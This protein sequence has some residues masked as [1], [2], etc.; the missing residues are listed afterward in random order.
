VNLSQRPLSLNQL[1]QRGYPHGGNCVILGRAGWIYD[2]NSMDAGTFTFLF[3]RPFA[4]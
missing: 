1:T 2:Q 4:C 3:N